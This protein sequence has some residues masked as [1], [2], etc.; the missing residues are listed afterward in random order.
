MA[1]GLS[2]PVG[3]KNSTDGSI[4]TALD[5]LLSARSPHRFLGIDQNGRSS[6]VTTMGNPDSHVVL[7]GGREGANY[8][9]RFTSDTEK[10]LRAAGLQPGFMVDCS[11]ANSAK[12]PRRQALVWRSILAQRRGGRTSI[13]G[14]ML[15]SNLEEGAQPLVA[16]RRKLRYG[17]SI[18][19]GCIDWVTTEKLLRSAARSEH[20]IRGSLRVSV[21]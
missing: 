8:Q 10:R 2:M 12:N 18:T 11:H 19:D 1:S 9:S 15:E 21:K 5:A 7:R 4:Q 3:F 14:A 20:K 17:V 13:I 16:D 6:V